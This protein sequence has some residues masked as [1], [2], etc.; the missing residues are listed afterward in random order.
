MRKTGRQRGSCT[1]A[2]VLGSDL[3]E[4]EAVWSREC[5]SRWMIAPSKPATGRAGQLSEEGVALSVLRP[6]L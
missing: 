5:H 1:D 6:Q 3:P 4:E 2:T